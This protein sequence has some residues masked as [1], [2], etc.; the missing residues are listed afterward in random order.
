MDIESIKTDADYRIIL[1]E[2]EAYM[3]AEPNTPEGEKL[4][5]LL[6]LIDAYERKHFPL[7]LFHPL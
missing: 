4:N 3:M 6:N 7:D 1:K 5:V 2:V